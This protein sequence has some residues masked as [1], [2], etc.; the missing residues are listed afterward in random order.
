MGS[1]GRA[2]T[3]PAH[4]GSMHRTM[5]G[6]CDSLCARG[7]SAG[8]ASRRPAR[9]R[10]RGTR[11]RRSL[12]TRGVEWLPVFG[13]VRGRSGSGGRDDRDDQKR[14]ASNALSAPT[15]RGGPPPASSPALQ[16]QRP[17]HCRPRPSHKRRAPPGRGVGSSAGCRAD[18]D[19]AGPPG[20]TPA[21]EVPVDGARGV[22]QP[23]TSSKP[24]Q[25]TSASGRMSFASPA[26]MGSMAA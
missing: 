12:G 20:Q 16:R 13:L 2:D 6:L 7:A 3:W 26:A 11:R 18:S 24:C 21:V 10:R 8:R 25:P 19:S 4:P 1:S 14:H 15:A 5:S 9:Q 17:V 22:R 23:T